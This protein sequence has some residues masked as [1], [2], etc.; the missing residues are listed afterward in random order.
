[1]M[2]IGAVIVDPNFFFPG[3]FGC[4]LRFEEKNVCLYVICIK[5]ACRQA[6]YCMQVS[7]FKKFFADYFSC[8]TFKQ[9]IVRQHHCC[10]LTCFEDCMDLLQKVQLFVACGGLEVLAVVNEI[11]FSFL[12]FFVCQGHAALYSKVSLF[13]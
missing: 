2:Y 4:R 8:F 12:A 3:L 1:M 11:I 10:L 13:K 6:K 5:N 9:D 7:G